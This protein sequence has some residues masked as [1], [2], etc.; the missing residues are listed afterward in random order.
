MHTDL[1]H[2]VRPY[3]DWFAETFEVARKE[4]TFD[5]DGVSIHGFSWGDP[6]KPAVVLL[7]GM[8]AHARCWAFIAP[9]L[10]E[11]YHLAA[12]DFSGMGDSGWRQSYSLE[13]RAEE[14]KG[15][16]QALGMR[17]PT[18]VC[19]S[20]GGSVGLTAV[21]G[22]ADFWARL[23]ICDMSMFRKQDMAEFHQRRMSRPGMP[24]RNDQPRAHRVYADLP[25]ALERFR[26][27][28]EQPCANDY[29]VEYMGLHS[30]RAADTGTGWQWKFDPG[31]IG[32]AHLNDDDFWL[33]LA[34]RFAALTLP[35]AMVYGEHSTLFPEPIAEH[36]RGLCPPS[37]PIVQ[38]PGAHHHLM[39]DQ[40]QALTG[41]LRGL[42]EALSS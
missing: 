2:M 9:M 17:A 18:L 41:T 4:H 30:L 42:L 13:Q 24:G 6:T 28:P 32:A 23:I 7:H 10:A 1:E 40:P 5:I 12:L 27:A 19:H 21:E 25:T 39:L 22:S 29:L 31:I 34:P 37:T 11:H 14:A 35:K 20:F 8:M 38:V 15:F 16:A 36:L 33:G 26:L 3:P